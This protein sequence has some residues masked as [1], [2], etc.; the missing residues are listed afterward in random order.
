MAMVR[1]F[2]E[3]SLRIELR[4]KFCRRSEASVESKLT[5]ELLEELEHGEISPLCMYDILLSAK[6]KSRESNEAP[7]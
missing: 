4:A 7:H 3:P 6:N 2:G 5:V 1:V